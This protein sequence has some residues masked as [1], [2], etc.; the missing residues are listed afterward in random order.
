MKSLSFAVFVLAAVML[1]L[2]LPARADVVQISAFADT[3]AGYFYEWPAVNAQRWGNGTDVDMNAAQ[4][5]GSYRDYYYYPHL[6]FDLS[7]LAADAETIHS[8]TLNLR[9]AFES[10][11]KPV[12][13]YR[14]SDDTWT[15]STL[16]YNTMPAASGLI[17]D[18]TG[19]SFDTQT[20]WA[21]RSLNV[22]DITADLSDG[23]LG[24]RLVNP[25]SGIATFQTRESGYA[26]YLEVNYTPIP[27]P[28]T[29]SVMVVGAMGLLNRRR[30]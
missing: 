13:V 8:V 21:T 10:Y 7:V 25:T 17:A 26:P 5:D 14:L 28:A 29:M 22:A 27:E 15:E 19:W 2:V 23:L 1:T 12:N 11:Y 18:T 20:L 16:T 3:E 6:M 9:S 30:K 4:Y 24:F